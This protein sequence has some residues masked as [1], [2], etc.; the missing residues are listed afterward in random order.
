MGQ[1]F[2]D[3]STE[4]APSLHHVVSLLSGKEDDGSKSVAD[5]G[6][7]VV[8]ISSPEVKVDW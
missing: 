4:Q 7:S 3:E 5:G 6:G 1:V 2:P 8:G